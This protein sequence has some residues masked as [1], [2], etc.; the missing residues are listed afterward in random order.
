MNSKR[1]YRNL[2]CNG[3]LSSF[4]VK[5]KESDLWIAVSSDAYRVEMVKEVEEALWQRRLQ[6]EAYLAAH[7]DF[8]N[9]LEPSFSLEGAPKLIGVMARAGNRAGVGPMAAVAGALAE[10]VGKLLLREAPEVIVENGG[11]LFIKVEETVKVG[12]YAGRSDLSGRLALRIDPEKTPLG[13][14]SSSG[15][16][17]P[18]LSF[19]HADVAMVLS[20]AVALADAV[21]TGLG[22]RVA[23][24]EDFTAALEYTRAIDE[25]RGA[26]VICAGKIAA[27]GEIELIKI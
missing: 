22:N 23:G 6:I 24:P 9:S 10:D 17:G 8:K 26:L 11:D 25:V 3:R 13:V 19:G 21:A 4:T 14:C 18:S 16:V 5:V 27:W 12:I 1:F 15:T 2:S 7:P 20:P